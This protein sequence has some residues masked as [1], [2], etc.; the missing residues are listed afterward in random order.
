MTLE[1]K[2]YHPEQYA[3]GRPLDSYWAATGGPEPAGT[4]ALAGD[5]TTDVAAIGVAVFAVM[6]G[7]KVWGWLKRT[8]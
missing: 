7:V 6:V 3:R 5:L 8:L 1:S 2:L 4:D